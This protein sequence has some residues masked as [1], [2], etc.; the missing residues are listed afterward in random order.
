MRSHIVTSK[1]TNIYAK[2]KAN[3]METS[4]KSKLPVHS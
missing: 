1:E 2:R 3:F 4:M